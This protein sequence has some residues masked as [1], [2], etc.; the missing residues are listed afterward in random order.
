M[1]RIV[2]N[3]LSKKFKIGSKRKTAL[4]NLLSLFFN[5]DSKVIQ[6]LNDISFTANDGENIGIIG[7]NGSGKSTLLM[8]LAGIYK[9]NSGKIKIN[10]KTLFLSIM[11]NGIMPNLTMRDNIFLSGS[12]LGLGQKDIKKKFNKIVEFSGLEEF[13]DTK[14]SKFS[15]GMNLRLAFSITIHCVSHAKPDIL[16]LDEIFGSGG[17]L[18][19]QKKAKGKMEQLVSGGATVLLVSHSL[20]LIKQ[21]CDKVIWLEKG[22]IK[23]IGKPKEVCDRYVKSFEKG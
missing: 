1:E 2:I 7:A 14:V 4:D 22:K 3:N 5:R 8:I 15:T 21:V 23:M 16:F 12:I 10:G 18:D 11:N 9:K 6:V 13:V 19:F 20:D 17:D